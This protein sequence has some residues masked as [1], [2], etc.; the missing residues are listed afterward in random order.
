MNTKPKFTCLLIVSILILFAPFKGFSQDVSEKAALSG[1]YHHAQEVFGP[2]VHFHTQIFDD[3][4]GSAQVYVFLFCRPEASERDG[5]IAETNGLSYILDQFEYAD[6]VSVVAGANK[7]HVPVMQMYR[8]LPDF[9]L[10]LK[11]MEQLLL[12]KTAKEGWFITHYLYISPFELWIKWHSPKY[13]G[14]FLIRSSD[15][16]IT[17]EDHLLQIQDNI[18]RSRGVLSDDQRLERI[19]KKWKFVESLCSSRFGENN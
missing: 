7:T 8:G 5:F 15:L 18:K 10:H 4:S 19:R 1:A 14:S 12:Q 3:L 17:D 9:I 2:L 13:P 16:Y 6:V 11:K